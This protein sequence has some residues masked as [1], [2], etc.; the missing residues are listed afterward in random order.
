[1]KFRAWSR[2]G[3][4]SGAPALLLEPLYSKWSYPPAGEQRYRC[5]ACQKSVT[6]L[7]GTPFSGIHD[8]S[9]LLNNA[10]CMNESLSV[11]KTAEAL[12]VHRNTAFRFRHLMTPV[13]ATHQPGELPGVAQAEEAFF[14]MSNKELKKGMPRKSHKRGSPAGKTGISTEQVA[15]LTA[16]S[17]GSRGSHITVLPP[18]LPPLPSRPP[19]RRS[20]APTPFCVPTPRAPIRSGRQAGWLGR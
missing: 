19:W 4:S 1:M 16:V 17:R 6:G 7:T 10:S 15:V 12:G 5:K 3:S 18:S 2:S 9:L 11:R 13:L 8:K 20:C 14:R